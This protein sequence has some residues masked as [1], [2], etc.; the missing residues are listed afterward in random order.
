MIDEEYLVHLRARS[1]RNH[2]RG[3][4]RTDAGC[5]VCHDHKF[6]P[7]TQTRVLCSWRRS[8]TTR[9]RR[10]WTATSR[11]TP[12]VMSLLAGADRAR[13]HATLRRRSRRPKRQIERSQA[14]ARPGFEAWLATATADSVAR[15]PA[16]NSISQRRSTTAVATTGPAAST[17]ERS[18]ASQCRPRLVDDRGRHRPSASPGKRVPFNGDKRRSLTDGAATSKETEPFTHRAWVKFAE[19]QHQ[20]RDRGPHGR[21][22]DAAAAAGICGSTAA[23]SASHMITLGPS[24]AVEGASTKHRCARQWHH[25]W[26]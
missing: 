21:L 22:A 8:S 5:A 12:P 23:G 18:S 2:R 26:S 15:S 16:T 6:D 20:R 10:P 11:T 1:R 13:V 7:I 24:N 17:T 14:D 19:A 25:V 9:R 3:V 4:A